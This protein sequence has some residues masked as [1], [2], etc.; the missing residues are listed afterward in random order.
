MFFNLYSLPLY[1]FSLLM[2][3]L[4][5]TAWNYKTAGGAKEFSLL[6]L[7]CALY[8]SAYGLE[9]S[10]FDLETVLFWLKIEYIG[11]AAIPALYILFALAYTEKNDRLKSDE[12]TERCTFSGR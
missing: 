6:A 8:S 1:I 9:I 4:A 5:F 2:L 10:S 11:I 7:A 12:R 3:I